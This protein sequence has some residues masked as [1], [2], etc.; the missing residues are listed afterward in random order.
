[1]NKALLALISFCLLPCAL[2]PTASAGGVKAIWGPVEMPNG[3]PAFRVYKDLGVQVYQVGLN[4]NQ[5]APSRPADATNPD[6]P[7]YRWPK[8]ADAAIRAGRRYGI[9]VSFLVNR[10]PSWANGGRPEQ[11]APNNADYARFLTAASR[12]YPS[13]RL[14]QIWGETNRRATFQPLP[15]ASPAGPRRYATLL[16]AAYGALKRRSRRNTVI[17]GMTIGFGPVRPRDFLRWMRLPNGKPPPL[18]WYGHNPFSPRF[19]NLRDHGY[20]GYPGARDMGDVDTF[21]AEI[22]RTYKGRYRAF[23]R[24]GPRLWLSEYTISSDRK[25]SDFEFFVSRREQ[26][27]W[28][29]AAYRIACRQPYVA[30]LG[31]IGLLDAPATEGR[32]VTTGLMTYEGFQKPAYHAYKRARCARR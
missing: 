7:A 28:V 14:W 16:N 20:R 24:R 25:N 3:S 1:M 2:A 9:K 5:T 10:S 26:A 15:R 29:T 4:W 22:R 30:G 19:P 8:Y 18:D 27:R 31:W 6:D 32:G 11:W 13:V 12:R 21:A 23:R 17:G